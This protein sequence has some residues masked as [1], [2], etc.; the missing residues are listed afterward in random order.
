M[1][2][3]WSSDNHDIVDVTITL[4]D[5]NE[6]MA[7]ANIDWYRKG[8]S[9]I[10]PSS[11]TACPYVI[12]VTEENKCGE[13]FHSDDYEYQCEECSSREFHTSGGKKLIAITIIIYYHYNYYYSHTAALVMTVLLA[14]MVFY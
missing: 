9:I 6:N 8:A 11:Y 14:C 10:V 1:I 13:E 5:N 3:I 7:Q 2:V 12:E 4:K